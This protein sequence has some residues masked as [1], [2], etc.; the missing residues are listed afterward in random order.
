M[1]DAAKQNQR[2]GSNT[3]VDEVQLTQLVRRGCVTATAFSRP[4]LSQADD[5][6]LG[7]FSLPNAIPASQQG[8]NRKS[9]GH[10]KK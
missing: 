3:G 1:P 10:N 4:N 5:A 8:L 7:Q 2:G 9:V 6:P